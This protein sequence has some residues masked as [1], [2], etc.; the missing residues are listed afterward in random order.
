MYNNLLVI[1][2]LT[3]LA[4]LIFLRAIGIINVSDSELIGYGLMIY[5]LSIFY[6]SYIQRRKLLLF[7]GSGIFLSGVLF[8]L[9]GNF[10]L[11]N[12]DQLLIPASLF[13]FSIGLFMVYLSDP[14]KKSI[15]YYALVILTCGVGAMALI[16]TNEIGDYFE[17]TVLITRIYWPV[18]IILLFV[19]VLVNRNAKEKSNS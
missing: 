10:D 14:S 16:S 8:F 18:I 6:S 7:I 19:V 12:I 15:M 9:T 3:F 5:G 4:L 11:K 1:Y 2:L 13:I 17:N